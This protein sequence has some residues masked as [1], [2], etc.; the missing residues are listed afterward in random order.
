M[1]RRVSDDDGADGHVAH[2]T[3]DEDE[4]VDDGDGNDDV[5]RQVFRTPVYGQVRFHC[6]VPLAVA[7]VA[8]RVVQHQIRQPARAVRQ[9]IERHDGKRSK[10][11]RIALT[12][13]CL[14][15]GATPFK[16]PN[17]WMTQQRAC[18]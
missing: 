9:R 4:D 6:K 1:H 10:L 8:G 7:A 14:P 3:G 16:S 5:E 12:A 11:M 2:H 13:S 17:K 18:Q 15:V